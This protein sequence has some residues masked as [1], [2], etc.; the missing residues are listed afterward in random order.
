MKLKKK[1]VKPVNDVVQK[2][3]KAK[4][5][6]PSDT[7]KP[8]FEPLELLVR[9]YNS[10]KDASKTIKEYLCLSV[11]RFGED[12]LPYVFIS[13]R[14]ESKDPDIYTGYLK[15]KSIKFPLEMLYSVMEQFDALSEECDNRGIE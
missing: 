4:S 1:S 10:Y 8:E 6:L 7:Y 9:E 3:E 11:I 2:K 15:G 12:G 13:T 14:Q 5:T